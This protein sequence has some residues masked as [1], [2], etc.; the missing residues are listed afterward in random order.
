M[1][2]NIY[3]EYADLKFQLSALAVREV[4]LK[5]AIIEDFKARK[6]T[7]EESEYGKFT[8][9]EGRKKWIYSTKVQNM[10]IDLKMKKKDE[11]ESGKAKVELGEPYIT[12]KT[13]E[14]NV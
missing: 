11:E 6:V 13:N 10:E 2:N 8:M 14:P 4:E 12:Y 3:K 7:K 9:S 5:S 1:K